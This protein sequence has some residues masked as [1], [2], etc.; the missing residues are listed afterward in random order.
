MTAENREWPE[1][2]LRERRSD[3][4]WISENIATFQLMATAAYEEAG[5]GAIVVDITSQPIPGGGHPFG[6]VVQDEIERSGDEDAKRLV[7]EYEPIEQELVVMLLKRS[8]RTSTY[9]LRARQGGSE[10]EAMD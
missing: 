1:W 5:R 4:G 2:A 9:R 8:N 3:L 7:R 6:Y 10:G